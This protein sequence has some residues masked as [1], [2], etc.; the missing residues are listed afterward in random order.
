MREKPGFPGLSGAGCKLSPD[1]GL[2]GW[3]RSADRACLHANSL[4]TGNLQGKTRFRGSHDRFYGKKRLCHI[5]FAQFSAQINRETISKNRELLGRN[6]ECDRPNRQRA[7]EHITDHS[8]AVSHEI[9]ASQQLGQT[10]IR[11][12]AEMS[13]KLFEVGSSRGADR[14]TPPHRSGRAAFPH[15]APLTST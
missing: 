15:S 1:E 13:L 7:F 2:A 5:G 4:L 14:S 12:A 6:R 11:S 3:R 10:D 9:D 8:F